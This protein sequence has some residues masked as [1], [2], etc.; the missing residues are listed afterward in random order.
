MY[1]T[2]NTWSTD[3]PTVAPYQPALVIVIAAQEG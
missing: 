2:G 3:F 1:V